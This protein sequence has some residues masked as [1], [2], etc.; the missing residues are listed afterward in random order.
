MK[1]LYEANLECLKDIS[2]LFAALFDSQILPCCMQLQYTHCSILFSLYNG[3]ASY[4]FVW[5]C[6]AV[7]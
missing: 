3:M 2:L 5:L 6:A 7:D 4:G 1:E